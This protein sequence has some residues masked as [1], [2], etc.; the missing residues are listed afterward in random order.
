MTKYKLGVVYCSITLLLNVVLAGCGIEEKQE[1]TTAM[2]IAKADNSSKK[3][4]LSKSTAIQPAKSASMVNENRANTSAKQTVKTT[5]AQNKSTKTNT[6]NK[7][8]VLKVDQSMLDDDT[9]QND[10]K[11]SSSTGVLPDMFNGNDKKKKVISGGLLTKD[12]T[13][14]LSDTVDGA[15]ISLELETN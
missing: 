2:N 9:D 4:I 10:Q 3:I 13:D 7:P 11:K 12:A 8:L 5:T 6:V 14:N 15:E 1:K